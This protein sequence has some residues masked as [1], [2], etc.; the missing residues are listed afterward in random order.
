M[1][2]NGKTL[3][4]LIDFEFIVNVELGLIRLIKYKYRDDRAFNLDIVDKSDRAILSLL[5]CRKNYNPL[6]IISTED[7]MSD[8]DGLYKSFMS[9]CLEEIL[10][11]SVSSKKIMNFVNILFLTS[12]KNTG[13]DT[14]ICIHNEI[15]ENF[16]KSNMKKCRFEY[17]EPITI[18]KEKDPIYSKDYTFF[19]NNKIDV[20]SYKNIY[21][22]NRQYVDE[23]CKNTDSV[24]TRNN[25]IV[26]ID[27]V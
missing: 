7:N 19:T 4:T 20:S 13:S 6:S 8:I 11:Y 12:D 1:I 21:M 10:Q 17:F 26:L 27:E 14:C 23:Y 5:K 18:L 9:D 25:R 3:H 16:I 24:F 2:N 15:Q 22:Y